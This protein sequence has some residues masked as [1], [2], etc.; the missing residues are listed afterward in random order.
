[1]KVSEFLSD[2]SRWT[3]HATARD[4]SGDITHPDSPNAVC[5]CLLG[6]IY[7]STD[8]AIERILTIKKIENHV[9]EFT[10]LW[11]DAPGRQFEEV[12]ALLVELD[13]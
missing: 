12:K 5:F 2:R 1:M 13:L 8:S 10:G 11:N 7:K 4:A 9:K 3:Q 6:A